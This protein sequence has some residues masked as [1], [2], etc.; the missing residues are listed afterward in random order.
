[1][2]L[3]ARTGPVAASAQHLLGSGM[4][5]GF[6]P[7]ADVR[8]V[9]V[10]SSCNRNYRQP[11]TPCDIFLRHKSPCITIRYSY[12]PGTDISE[13]NSMRKVVTSVER[14][15]LLKSGHIG[16]FAIFQEMAKRFSSQWELSN[17]E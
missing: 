4:F 12:V 15:Q 2:P 10:R 1:M 13:V 16:G 14:S 6:R 17:M 11:V 5:T 9:S 8:S 7:L 3:C